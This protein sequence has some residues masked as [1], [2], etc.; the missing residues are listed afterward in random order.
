MQN[1]NYSS[2]S[3]FLS[4]MS[5]SSLF[6]KLYLCTKQKLKE[7]QLFIPTLNHFAAIGIYIYN[8][9]VSVWIIIKHIYI[10][11]Q[12]LVFGASFGNKNNGRW[13]F[14]TV[15]DRDWS[16]RNPLVVPSGSQFDHSTS[17]LF[18]VSFVVPL[19]VPTKGHGE[20]WIFQHFPK[21]FFK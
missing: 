21:K 4:S 5:F 1:I 2:F 20:S 18:H 7:L 13:L 3:S 15:I 10:Y 9:K 16:G 19:R 14:L 6:I 8:H 12:K 11:S 17:Y